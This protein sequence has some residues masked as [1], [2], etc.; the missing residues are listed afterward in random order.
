MFGR[1]GLVPTPGRVT[2]GRDT[3]GRET[4]GREMFGG[5]LTGRFTEGRGAGLEGRAAARLIEG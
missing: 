4:F 3:F 5:R 1:A 2:F